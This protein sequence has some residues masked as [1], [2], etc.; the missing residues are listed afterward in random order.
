MNQ[1]YIYQYY[2]KRKQLYGLQ[3][4][5]PT[6]SEKFQFY[7]SIHIIDTLT[8]PATSKLCESQPNQALATPASKFHLLIKV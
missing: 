5:Q 2:I 4:R 3:I 6:P 7:L 1:K 8:N